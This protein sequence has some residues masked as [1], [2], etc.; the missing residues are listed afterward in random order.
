MEIP[1]HI[2]R[3]R[4]LQYAAGVGAMAGFGGSAFGQAQEAAT[5]LRLP[6]GTEHVFVGTAADIFKDLLCGQQLHQS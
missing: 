1:I 5:D 2:D 4:F 3:R 6:D